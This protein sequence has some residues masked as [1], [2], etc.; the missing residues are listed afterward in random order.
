MSRETALSRGGSGARPRWARPALLASAAV[1][2]L[3]PGASALPAGARPR[4]PLGTTASSG[5]CGTPGALDR[6]DAVSAFLI[7]VV[8]AVPS[9]APDRFAERVSPILADLAA[10]DAWWRS[11]DPTR[12]PRLDLL[13]GACDSTLGRLDLGSIRLPREGAYY[14]DPAQG[15]SRITADLGRAP[16][17]L[18]S[19]DKKYLVYYD[20]PLQRHDVCGTSPVGPARGSGISVVYLDSLCGGDLGAGRHAATTAVHELLHNLGARPLAHPCVGSP[21]HACDST[22]DVL[23]YTVEEGTS[24]AD[25]HLDVGRDDYYGL[26]TGR[27]PG[28][29]VRDSPFLERVGASRPAPFEPPGFHATGACTRLTLSWPAAAT[30]TSP[31]YRL[32]RNGRLLTETTARTF[33]DDARIGTTVYTLRVADADGHLSPSRTIRFTIP[34]A[35]FLRPSHDA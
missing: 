25:L 9:D 13:Q 7:H 10:I 27:A 24:L 8:Y 11:E 19:P 4:V 20:G 32:Y 17:S 22:R 12:A 2:A 21:A 5:W 29:D 30:A 14:A 15:F 33:T 16:F 6:P 23:Y 3:A 26:Q 35:D 31:V 18:D 34:G 1:A 28:G